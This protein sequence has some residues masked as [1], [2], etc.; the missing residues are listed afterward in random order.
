[1]KLLA[2]LL[3]LASR[4]YAQTTFDSEVWVASKTGVGTASPG[5]RFESQG[6]SATSSWF[7]VSGVDLSPAL[8]VG[9]DGNL[10]LSTASAARV[11]VSGS[12][13]AGDLALELR[14]GNVYPAASSTQTTFGYAG[15]ALYRHAIRT[16]HAATASSNTLTFA[17]WSPADASGAVGTKEVMTLLTHSTGTT[18]HVVPPPGLALSTNTV[19]LIVSNGTTVGAGTMMRG[20]EGT[21]S[22]ALIKEGIQP[23]EAQAEET[24]YQEVAGLKHVRFRY[25]GSKGQAQRG[26]L[27]EEAPESI[28]A[29]GKAL[30]MD[31]RLLNA[32]MAA[33]ELLRRL[34]AG[35][36]DAAVLG[37]ESR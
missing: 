3:L 7:Q 37:G 25:K 6:S 16:Q 11:S 33:K 24:A 36:A 23:L 12:G 20:S 15:G 30:S 34:S 10:D 32:E 35:E 27:Y 14:G 21:A 1:M 5:A 29:P 8:R 18:V 2:L 31:R 22:S 26:L 19:Q 17:L 4:A 13:D 9:S 28:R